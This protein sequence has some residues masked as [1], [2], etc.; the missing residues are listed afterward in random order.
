[1]IIVAQ[2]VAHAAV[3]VDGRE[4]AAIGRGLLL[5]AC[6]VSGD[7]DDSVDWLA[8]KLAALRVF[9]DAQ[10]LTNLA[11]S[12]VGGAVLVV[13]QFT[14][15]AD[16][17]KGRRPS[18]TAAAPPEEGRRLVGR[19]VARLSSA[20]VPVQQGVFGAAMRVS[21]VNDGPFTLLLDSRAAPGVST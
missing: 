7:R 19:L 9:E 18:F 5:L 14:L 4:V 17:R 2:R 15:A 3:E 16:W 12:E 1:M 13:P 10:G 8:A 11:L 6:A 20:G 21:L